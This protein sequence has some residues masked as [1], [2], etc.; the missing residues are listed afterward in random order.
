MIWKNIKHLREDHDFKQIYIANLLHIDQG[1]YSRY[2]RG[3]TPIT[4]ET[5]CKLADF[6]GTSLDYL[7]DR[8]K[9]KTPYE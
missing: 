9:N 2:E 8:T 4:V 5:L 1:S 7:A 6:Y 3:E